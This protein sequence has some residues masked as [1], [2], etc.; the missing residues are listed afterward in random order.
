MNDTLS[1]F[2]AQQQQLA[3]L[4]REFLAQQAAVH[5]RF[6]SLQQ[7]AE[8]TLRQAYGA[9]TQGIPVAQRVVPAH[10]QPVFE[11]G[12]SEFP[13]RS[14]RAASRRNAPSASPWK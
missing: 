6:L 9:S 12:N 7:S 4:H 8:A 2:M 3:T 11:R 5:E 14:S 10:P 1:R 13:R